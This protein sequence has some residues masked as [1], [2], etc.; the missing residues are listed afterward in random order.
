MVSRA[1][2]L[3]LIICLFLIILGFA[4]W[5]FFLKKKPDGQSEAQQWIKPVVKN[6]N[7]TIKEITQDS[8]KSTMT[9]LLH[10][11]MPV[12]LPL[13]SLSYRMKVNGKPLAQGSQQKPMSV[14]AH[15][16][17]ALQ[18]PFNTNIGNLAEIIRI[19]QQDSTDV[20]IKMIAYAHLPV[21]GQ[22]EIPIDLEKK[23]YIPKLPHFE[24]EKIHISD[25][26]L[27]G[28]KLLVDMKATNYTAIP[29]TIKRMNY[30]FKMS[31]NV[32]VKGQEDQ[33]VV[34]KQLGSQT[35]TIP[36]NLKLDQMGEAAFKMLFKSKDTPYTLNSQLFIISDMP[37]MRKINMNI[38]SKG[39][40][41]D[42]KESVKQLKKKD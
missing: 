26:S 6:L 18:V 41:K 9:F 24:V 36:I 33:D 4:G 15:A 22:K 40:L 35:I 3:A 28:G 37:F 2:S 20:G 19:K 13:D 38:K 17:G 31:D 42:L 11:P 25:M 23:V 16:D 39:N 27:K 14:K 7:L 12:T 32:D 29:F 5:W 21:I 34:F 10:N 30:H 8:L 1:R